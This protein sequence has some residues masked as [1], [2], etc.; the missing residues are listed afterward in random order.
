M[1]LPCSAANLWWFVYS[2]VLVSVAQGFMYSAVS[3]ASIMVVIP[4]MQSTLV[5]RFFFAMW[6]NPEHE[7][8]GPKVVM[9][10]AI[11]IIG[12]CAVAIDTELILEALRVP[13]GLAS[14][15]RWQI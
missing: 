1:S 6:L 5:F 13:E 7:I 11:S 12:A 4:L 15:L 2:G 10:T 14:L 8:F 9:G 3:V